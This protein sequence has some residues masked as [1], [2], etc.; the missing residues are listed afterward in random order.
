VADTYDA[1]GRHVP[2]SGASGG[3]A[4]EDHDLGSLVRN[5]AA[6]LSTLMRQELAL[7]KAEV[8]Q[9]AVEGGKAAGLL[10][11]AGV[12]GHLVLVFLSLTLMWLLS[13][14]MHLAWASLLVAL[15]WGIVAAVLFSQGRTRLRRVDP[16]PRQTVETVQED[17]QWAKNRN[18]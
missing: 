16:V 10:G 1:P 8:K 14:V 9:E 4:P 15:L 18:S 17:V 2:G 3:T 6:D 5:V 7:A 13:E 11:G 12:A